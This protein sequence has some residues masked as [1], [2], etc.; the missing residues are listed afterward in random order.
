ME[1]VTVW[2]KP[3]P[4]KTSQ[5]SASC[6]RT[7]DSGDGSGARD[8]GAGGDKASHHVITFEGREREGKGK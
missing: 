7:S 6:L 5:E 2:A 4:V 3:R 1:S 8:A